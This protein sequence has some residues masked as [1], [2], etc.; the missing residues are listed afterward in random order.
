MAVRYLLARNSALSYVSR[1][2]LL[3]LVLSV[4]VLVVVV[5][6]VNGFERELRERILAVL[7]QITVIAPGGLPESLAWEVTE[8]PLP[9]SLQGLAPY[10]QGNV[11]LTANGQI[12]G[13]GLTGIESSSY[14]QITDMARYTGSGSLQGLDAERYGIVLGQ[15]LAQRLGVMAGDQVLVILPVGAMTPAGAIPRQ[16]RFTVVDIFNSQS[17]LD[18]QTALTSL[19]AAQKLFRA[20]NTVHGLQGRLTDLFSIEAARA[21]LYDLLSETPIRVSSWRNTFG[22]LYQAIAVQKLTMFVLLS[23]LVAVA[24]F[25]LVSGLMMIVDQRKSD[26]AVLR[27]LGATNLHIVL[28]FAMLGIMLSAGGI[29]LG[30]ALGAAVAKGLPALYGMATEAWE[31][32]LMNQ[33]F[34]SYLP[35]DVRPLD[36]A[37]IG[38]GALLLAIAA[39]LYPAWRA[40]RLLPSRVLAQE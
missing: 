23:F 17:Q 31:L 1:L 15:T 14:A 36:L 37:Q 3:G 22:N 40:A 2:A 38:A 19:P 18:G 20:G 16:R 13:A 21:H 10:I 25:N 28:I 33:Y 8:A 27:T 6:V 34:I 39:T 9:D 29:G 30:I 7:P 5:S 4:L 35:V 24:A 26:V 12:A 11:L 32:D